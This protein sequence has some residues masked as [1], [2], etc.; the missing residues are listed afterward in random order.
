MSQT[1]KIYGVTLPPMSE[2]QAV[3]QAQARGENVEEYL[4]ALAIEALA[5]RAAEEAPET[6]SDPLA[7][8][9]QAMERHRS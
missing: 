9:E 2:E 3:R 5:R 4:S 7:F 6:G 8:W 1:P